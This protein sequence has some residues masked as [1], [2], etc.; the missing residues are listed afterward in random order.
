MS[1]TA[2]T[3]PICAHPPTKRRTVYRG[4]LGCVEQCE[5]CGDGIT[6]TQ[7]EIDAEAR[8]ALTKAGQ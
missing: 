4:P 8:A 6:T 1:E 3:P 2:F 7:E 5:V